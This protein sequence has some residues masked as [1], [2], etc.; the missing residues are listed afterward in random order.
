MLRTDAVWEKQSLK[1][2][3]RCYM[4]VSVQLLSKVQCFY[5]N[6]VLKKYQLFEPQNIYSIIYEGCNL[7]SLS[8]S[9]SLSCRGRR[10]H[11]GL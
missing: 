4:K 11:Q 2:W 9:Y 5:F 3:F 6:Q 10:E 1:D 8:L 7:L